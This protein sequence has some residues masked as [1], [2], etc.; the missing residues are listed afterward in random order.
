MSSTSPAR[1]AVLA[2]VALGGAAGSLLRCALEVA[3]PVADGWP[4]A[5]L[6]ANVAGSGALG[7][8][9]ARGER[10][11]Q[12]WW[13]RPGVGT[14]LL[15]GFTTFSTYAVQVATLGRVGLA[16]SLAYLVVT[17]VLCVGAAW[18]AGAVEAGAAGERR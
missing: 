18:A 15:G 12:A 2:V 13:V 9:V 5:T 10:R 3:V 6:L 4:W 1:P 14:G 7:W 17:P 16:T 11:A 8:L